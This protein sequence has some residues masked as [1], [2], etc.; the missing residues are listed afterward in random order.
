[1]PNHCEN[2]NTLLGGV[3]DAEEIGYVTFGAL[4]SFDVN[5]IEHAVLHDLP[6]LRVIVLVDLKYFQALQKLANQLWF[7]NSNHLRYHPQVV[8]SRR[9]G[10]SKHRYLLHVL[11]NEVQLFQVEM[12]REWMLTPI[13]HHIH[14]M[15]QKIPLELEEIVSKLVYPLITSSD[16]KKLD[17]AC[18]LRLLTM[19]HRQWNANVCKHI[20]PD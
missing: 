15:S 20:T 18:Q 12:P 14:E 1:M 16:G 5:Q 11:N 8:E 4:A 10:S 9:V 3:S 17:D 13:T 2:I 6:E 19:R 7:L